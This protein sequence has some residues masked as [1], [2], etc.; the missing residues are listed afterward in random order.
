MGKPNPTEPDWS[1]D[2]KWIAFT[3]QTGGGFQINVLSTA[4]EKEAKL[5]VEG[6]DP[7][8][9]PNSRTL[10]YCRRENGGYVLAML[11]VGTG[12]H[13]DLSRISGISSQ[14]Q[15]SWAR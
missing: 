5:S 10:I 12:Q 8:W 2:G 9:A 15:P 1:P 4:G 7:S 14:S 11:D 13:K 3:T 6:E